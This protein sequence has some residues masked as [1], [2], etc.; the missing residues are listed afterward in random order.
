MRAKAT[1][2]LRSWSHR[3]CENCC[4]KQRCLGNSFTCGFG[5]L[6]CKPLLLAL[7]LMDTQAASTE[8]LAAHVAG[9]DLGA[10]QSLGLG[11][12]CCTPSR[13]GRLSEWVSCLCC[14]I[15]SLLHQRT[16]CFLGAAADSCCGLALTDL[17]TADKATCDTMLW[18]ESQQM[19]QRLLMT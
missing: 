10:P 1:H 6:L 12:P 2:T 17:N 9:V 19:L 8:A 3:R 15:E 4:C 5:S 14:C 13:A 18:L 11:P 16:G 7:G